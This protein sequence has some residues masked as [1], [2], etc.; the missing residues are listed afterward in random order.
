[1]IVQN[2]SVLAGTDKTGLAE[3]LD[4]LDLAPGMTLSIV[5]PTGSGKS[6]LLCDIEQLACGD[7]VSRR[8]VLVNG[9]MLLDFQPNL[10]ATLSQKTHFIM[11]VSVEQFIR[12]HTWSKGVISEEALD[13]RVSI[14]IEAAN[15]LCGEPICRDM[16]LQILSGGQSRA[17]MIADVALV[18]DAP[19]VLID[20]I[21]NAGIDKHR[22]LDVLTGQ[23]KIVIMATHDPVLMLAGQARLIMSSGGMHSLM[24][25]SEYEKESLTRLAELDD[26]LLRARDVL[27]QGKRISIAHCK[28]TELCQCSSSTLV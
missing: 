26:V 12:K 10:V 17:L 27:R 9:E 8:T 3:P 19:I 24:H 14:V 1:M 28:T 6:A 15:T 13:E 23:A 2:I 18:S 16:P 21:E 7:T 20:E 11:N 5:G 22:A 4:R 25:I